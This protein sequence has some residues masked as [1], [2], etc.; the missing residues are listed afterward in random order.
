MEH[1]LALMDTVWFAYPAW[2]VLTVGIANYVYRTPV[3]KNE[4]PSFEDASDF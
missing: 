2:F 3:N 1:V 4:A